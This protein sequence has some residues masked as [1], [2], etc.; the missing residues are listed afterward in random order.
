MNVEIINIGDELLIGQVVNT[1]CSYMSK[2]LNNAGIDVGY[3][4]VV[5]DNYKAIEQ[6]VTAALHRADAVLITGGLGPTKDDVTKNCLN[7]MFGGRLTENKE[8]SLHVE[9]IFLARNLPYTATNRS[10][11][12]VP[13]CCRIIFNPTGT[14][15]GMIFHKDGKLVISLPGVP[16]EMETMMPKAVETIL[17]HFKPQTVIHRTL[18]VSG[19]GESFLSDRLEEFEKKLSRQNV[20]AFSLAYLP[21]AGMIKLRLTAKGGDREQV[22]KKT[23]E[24]FDELAEEIKQFVVSKDDK[25]LAQMIG[26]RLKAAGKTVCTAESCTGGNIAH[27]ITLND[28]ASAYFKGSCVAYSNE[29]KHNVLKVKEQTLKEFHAVSRQVA[30]E[31]AENALKIFDTDYCIATTGLAGPDSDGTDT[32]IGTVYIA[33]AAKDGKTTVIKNCY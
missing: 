24:L 14:A 28:G 7:S 13:D 9:K 20:A 2:A 10:Q 16:F 21:D 19:I 30:A 32:E 33:V 23:D 15:P 5:G 26:Q 3:I 31:M 8:V 1:N 12:M 4:T 11:A 17:N 22:S 18:L 27:L 29:I 25:N 6:A